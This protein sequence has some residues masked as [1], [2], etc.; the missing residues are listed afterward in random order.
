MICL[1]NVKQKAKSKRKQETSSLY[2]DRRLLVVFGIQTLSSTHCTDARFVSTALAVIRTGLVHRIFTNSASGDF[3]FSYG[4][5]L[6][7]FE[8]KALFSFSFL[9]PLSVV[10]IPCTVFPCIWSV[11]STESLFTFFAHHP[12]AMGPLTTVAAA[13]AA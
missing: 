12:S 7:F 8:I 13:A 1:E 3:F 11:N 5:N 10:C 9:P 2:L 6:A 4:S